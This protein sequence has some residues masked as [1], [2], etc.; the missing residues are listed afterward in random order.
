MEW[1]RGGRRSGG[2]GRV[3]AGGAAFE[4]RR[5][6]ERDVAGLLIFRGRIF[7][8][9]VRRTY[10][11]AINDRIV[12]RGYSVCAGPW[13]WRSWRLWPW[14]RVRARDGDGRPRGYRRS[15]FR[16]RD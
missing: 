12:V 15:L 10:E 14:P 3:G 5:Y 6:I 1:N 7:Q 8:G 11:K 4:R 16:D 2:A 9:A 13:T